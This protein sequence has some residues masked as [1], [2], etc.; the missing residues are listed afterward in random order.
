MGWRSGGKE[1][2]SA[3]VGGRGHTYVAR[4]DNSIEIWDHARDRAVA[5]LRGHEGTITALA[6]APEQGLLFSTSLDGTLG[7]WDLEKNEERATV[8]TAEPFTALAVPPGADVVYAGTLHGQIQIWA[9]RLRR[10]QALVGEKGPPIARLVVEGDHLLARDVEGALR[11]FD[12]RTREPAPGRELAGA[13]TTGKAP[14]HGT[15]EPWVS[16]SARRRLIEA[17]NR[18]GLM[19]E[20]SEVKAVP[21]ERFFP[22]RPRLEPWSR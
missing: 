10:K 20:G 4:P 17:E 5:R 3:A 8:K 21:P 22:H 18:F 7:V 9:W 11:A 6:L 19:I 14:I 13:P 15:T 16:K 12:L 2:A 1:S